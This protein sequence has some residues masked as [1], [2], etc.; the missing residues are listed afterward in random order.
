MGAY[1]L[2]TITSILLL[3]TENGN[4]YYKYYIEH[5]DLRPWITIS[6]LILDIKFILFLRAFESFGIYFAIMLAVAR[7]IFSFLLILFLI[8]LSFAHAFFI[9][10][11]PS[12][13][14]GL[15]LTIL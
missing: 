15:I 14:L 10:L 4:D 8:I 3:T 2:P 13:Y 11:K 12:Y 7:K 1:L 9:L 5:K 6:C